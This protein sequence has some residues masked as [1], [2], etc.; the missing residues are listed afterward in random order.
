MQ[1]CE[2]L[3]LSAA[4]GAKFK[5]MGVPELLKRAVAPE[6][7]L[8]PPDAIGAGILLHLLASISVLCGTST[9]GRV[10]GAHHDGTCEMSVHLRLCMRGS[11]LGCTLL[12]G[13]SRGKSMTVT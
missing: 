11:L 1:D 8:Q 6:S 12:F 4:S 2:P 5:F 10:S 13:V 3:T 9:S 7:A